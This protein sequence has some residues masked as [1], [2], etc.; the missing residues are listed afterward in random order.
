MPDSKALSIVRRRLPIIATAV[1]AAGALALLGCA[2]SGISLAS[3]MSHGAARTAAA[4]AATPEQEAKLAQVSVGQPASILSPEMA[5]LKNAEIPLV[6]DGVVPAPPFHFAGDAASFERAADCLAAANW[7]EAGDDP[8]GERAVSQV[9][10]N[11]V[12][13]PA[14]A[15]TVCGVIFTGSD[16]ETG[17]QFTVTCDG[18]MRRQPSPAAWRRAREIAIAALNGAVDAEIGTATHSHTDWVYPAWSGEMEK[19]ARQGTH[20]FF[21]WPGP[22][23]G[24]AV[25]TRAAAVEEPQI[26]IMAPLAA[27]HRI[28]DDSNMPA[29]AAADGQ[30]DDGKPAG[31]VIASQSD[32]EAFIVALDPAAI[33]D[34]Y[35]AWAKALCAE[36]DYC[37]VLGWLRGTAMPA[38]FPVPDGMLGSM[39]F[40]YMRDE[41]IGFERSLWDCKQI[42]TANRTACMRNRT[43]ASASAPPPTLSLPAVAD[44]G[45]Q[46]QGVAKP[47]ATVPPD[48]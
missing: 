32:K 2:A 11:R 22:W 29:L 43:I 41:K 35:A 5:R 42:E 23:G 47:K 45:E 25:L 36:R 31:E 37:R 21:R 18:S 17:C 46:R 7:Y 8:D 10:L 48:A 26:A 27:A 33:P 1:I 4:K 13:H 20:L 24:K 9:V 14:F 39:A 15:K 44:K 28:G 34:S 12:R 16:R 40:G 19:I 6:A 30:P 3:L 38:K